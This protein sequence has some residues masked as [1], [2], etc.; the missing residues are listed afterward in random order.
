MIEPDIKG[1]QENVGA[2]K[3]V[4]VVSSKHY[5]SICDCLASYV[6]ANLQICSVFLRHVLDAELKAHL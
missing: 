6:H 4:L 5:A 3:C 2:V 1:P